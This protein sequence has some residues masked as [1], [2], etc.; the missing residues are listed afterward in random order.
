M[1]LDSDEFSSLAVLYK[2]FSDPTRVKILW[3]LQ[4]N[5]MCV[6][7]LAV[8]LN[9]TKSAIS[10]QLKSLRLTNLVKFRKE[11]KVVYYSLADDHVKTIFEN[12]VAHI[13]E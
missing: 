1:M 10:H 7:D 5:E 2:M 11:G 4:C 13:N 9:M 3:A 12:G 6:C 8:L